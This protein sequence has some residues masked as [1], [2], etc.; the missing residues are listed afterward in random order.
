MHIPSTGELISRFSIY[1]GGM[2][3]MVGE[4]TQMNEGLTTRQHKNN[5][6][7]GCPTKRTQTK[8]GPVRYLDVTMQA[9]QASTLTTEL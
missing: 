2:V 6:V 4:I 5:S 9:H 3:W 8:N 7:V 1:Q